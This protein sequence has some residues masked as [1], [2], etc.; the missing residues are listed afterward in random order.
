MPEFWACIRYV[1]ETDVY[2]IP[3][4]EIRQ[5]DRYGNFLPLAPTNLNDF[6]CKNK[7]YAKRNCVQPCTKDHNHTF[8]M[9]ADIL[10]LGG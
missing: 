1:R 8:I 10:L 2:V 3:C 7:Y 6:S 5:R 4:T 9:K